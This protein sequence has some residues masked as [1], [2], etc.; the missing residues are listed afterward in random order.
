MTLPAAASKSAKTFCFCAR[1]GVMPPLVLL[2][3]AAK[4]RDHPDT[5][6]LDPGEYADAEYGGS[7]LIP[8]PP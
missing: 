5:A 4:L 7:R 6:C 1:F 8:K 3:A 2:A